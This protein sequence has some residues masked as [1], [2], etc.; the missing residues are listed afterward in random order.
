M[1]KNI[2]LIFIY[3]ISQFVYGQ[4]NASLIE[5]YRKMALDYN[6]DLNSAEK[7]ISASIELLK[8]AR[9]YMKPKLE[10]GAYCQYTGNPMQLMLD[11]PSINN[12]ISFKG[13]SLHYGTSVSLLQP[14]YLGGRLLETIRT[15]QYNQSLVT[16]TFD[17]VR[18]SVCFQTDVQYWNTVASVELMSLFELSYK[19]IEQLKQIVEDRVNVGVADPQDLLMVEVKLNNSHYQ[20]L[21]SKNEAETNRMALNSLIGNKLDSYVQVDSIITDSVDM[22]NNNIQTYTNRPEI[23]MAFDKVNIKRSELI[24][25]DSKYKPQFYVEAEG[26]YYSPGYNFKTDLNINYTLSAKLSVPIFD[27]G[28]RKSD[29]RAYEYNV[30]IEQNN[31]YKIQDDMKLEEQKSR[32][33]LL[34][35]TQRVKLTNSSLE[36]AD[37]NENKAIERYNEGK[38]SIVEVIDA[39]IYRLTTQ[40]NYVQAKLAMQINYAELLKAVDAY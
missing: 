39:H 14:V 18:S 3:C 7:H 24:I 34:Q 25:N 36:K 38:S 28:K 29:K 27:W 5:N 37:E 15:S 10:G 35:S 8:S 1:K 13:E 4:S 12:P 21:K 26:G 32:L 31:L 17:M 11:I 16:N 6:H 19:S 2:I 22:S 30:E 9:D 33:N 40:I 20:F 23:R